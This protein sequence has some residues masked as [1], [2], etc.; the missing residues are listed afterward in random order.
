MTSIYICRRATSILF[1]H[2]GQSC[3]VKAVAHSDFSLSLLGAKHLYLIDFD[4]TNLPN[5]KS[6][7]ETRYPDV[8]VCH[9]YGPL[10]FLRNEQHTFF[11]SGYNPAG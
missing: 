10:N 1:A 5:L 6:T 4:P 3:L 11:L 2:E 8:K 7:I 9:G